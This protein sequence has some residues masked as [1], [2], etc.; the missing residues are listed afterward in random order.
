MP[1][2]AIFARHGEARFRAMETQALLAACEGERQVVSTGG[3]IIT[4][5]ANRRGYGRQRR[6]RLP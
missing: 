1:I 5:D 4:A 6:G 2:D 3:G